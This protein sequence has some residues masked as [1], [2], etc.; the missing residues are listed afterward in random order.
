MMNPQKDHSTIAF[1]LHKI[2]MIWT[3]Q[4]VIDSKDQMKFETLYG[5]GVT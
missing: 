1:F 4:N 5:L 3:V 2:F